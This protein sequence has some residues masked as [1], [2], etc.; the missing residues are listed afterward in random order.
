M[1]EE[2]ENEAEEEESEQMSP[3]ELLKR[4]SEEIE[5]QKLIDVEKGVRFTDEQFAMLKYETND[6]K[7][8]KTLTVRF[9]IIFD[10]YPSHQLSVEIGGEN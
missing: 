8:L 4:C 2:A 10:I 5:Q 9:F 6:V 1:E 7:T 3:E